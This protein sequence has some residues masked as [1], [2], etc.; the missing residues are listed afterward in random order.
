MMLQE[1][2]STAP[3]AEETPQTSGF[4]GGIKREA[5]RFF[6]DP[7]GYA[8][9]RFMYCIGLGIAIAILAV[10]VRFIMSIV[11]MSVS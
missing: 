7:F 5:Q 9:D 1:D 4:V 2:V 11:V 6:S 8:I 10:G 3:P